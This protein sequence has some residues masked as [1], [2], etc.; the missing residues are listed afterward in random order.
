MD[1]KKFYKGKNIMLT[2][3]TGFVGKVILN[4]ILM[5]LSDF[6]KIYL[7]VREK[8]NLNVEQRMKKIFDSYLFTRFKVKFDDDEVFEKFVSERIVLVNGDLTLPNLGI[9]SEERQCIID[10]VNVII[11]C[12]ASVKFDDELKVALGI[13]YFGAQRMLDLAKECKN[14]EVFTHIST[15]Y[16]NCDREGVIEEK[17]Y[18]DGKT[19]VQKTI[20]EILEMSDEA[21]KK[22]EKKIIGKF[23]N[24]YSFTKNLAEK[25]L[26]QNKGNV[27]LVIWRPAIIASAEKD[28]FPGW[29]DTIAAAGAIIVLSGLGIIHSVNVKSF[30]SALDIIPIDHVVNGLLIAT[31]HAGTSSS[32]KLQIYNNGSSH[33]NPLSIAFFTNTIKKVYE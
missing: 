25:S 6:N 16:V 8:K 1:L 9:S 4:K 11:N 24:T 31:C 5:S 2:G 22:N 7:M 12:A 18:D 20:K 19:N 17:I 28:P 29:T 32:N 15:A 30:T 23:P 10:N 21:A 33:S 13:N 27:K 26:K 3:C 14:L